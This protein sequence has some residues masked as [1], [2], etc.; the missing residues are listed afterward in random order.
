MNHVQRAD[1]LHDQ[2]PNGVASKRTVVRT[3]HT[4]SL[5][6]SF[7]IGQVIEVTA[8]LC[9]NVGKLDC[10]PYRSP[11]TLFASS[12][13]PRSSRPTRCYDVVVDVSPLQ[14]G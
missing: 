5:T 4:P 12:A 2:Q 10:R 7:R 6:P 9:V 1:L 14:S 11:D 13:E 8:S 3:A